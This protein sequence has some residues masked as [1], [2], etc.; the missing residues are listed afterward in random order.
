MM[1]RIAFFFILT[2]T[3]LIGNNKI[4]SQAAHI[5]KCKNRLVVIAHRGDHTEAPENT[6]AAYK[7]AIKNGADYVEID[8]R[9]TK[10]GELVIMHDS[11]IDRMTNGKGAVREMTYEE[12][13]KW[14]V[15]EKSH[16]EWQEQPIP[17]FSEVLEL[18]HKK[19][20]IYLDFKDASVTKSLRLIEKYGMQKNVV[21][22]INSEE[23]FREWKSIAPQM[24]LMVSLPDSIKSATAL[25]DFITSSGVNIL[26]GSYEDYTPEMVK[27]AAAKNFPVW[28]DIQ[29]PHEGPEEWNVALSKGLAGLQTDHPKLLVDYLKKKG[30]R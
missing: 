20:N 27:A 3:T 11:K 4:Y 6:L 1:K 17:T 2:A 5:P 19:I 7:N 26:D 21:V 25:S 9:T 29:S 12:L 10:D 13:K 8:L 23:Q 14:P 18:C 24:P 16:P 15:I 30:V 22:Y 28:P